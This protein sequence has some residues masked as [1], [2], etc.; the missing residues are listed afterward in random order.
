[1][2][3]LVTGG[4]GFIGSNLVEALAKEHQITVLDN[5]HT[6]SMENLNGLQKKIRVL[7]GSCNDCLSLDLKPDLIFHLGIP[8]SSPMYRKNPLLVGE[9]I[10]GMVAI[11]ELARRSGSPKVVFASSSSLYNGVPIPHREDAAIPVSDFYTEARLAVERVAELYYRLYD[12]DYAGLRFFSVYGPHEEAKKQYANMVTQFLWEMQADRP[13]VIYGNGEQT[14]D[15]TFVQDVVDALILASKKGTGIF[16]VGTGKAHSFNHVIEILNKKLGKNLLPEY[17][18][19]PIKNYVMHTQA[20]MSK[21]KKLGFEPR[22][23]LEDG[24]DRLI[25]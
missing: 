10:N 3:I 1:M 17:K 20:D 11:M 8:S 18:G 9:A 21:T 25:R 6:G 22:F 2:D 19:N 16:N 24:I 5:F 15:F 7:K 12:I 13:P 23:S 4:A 14:R